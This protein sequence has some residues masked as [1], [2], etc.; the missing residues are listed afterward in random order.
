[1][2]SG[3]YINQK[4]KY[5]MARKNTAAQEAPDTSNVV[6]EPG[7]TNPIARD[8]Y[9]LLDLYEQYK[10]KSAVIRFLGSKGYKTGDIAR[11]MD[12]IYQHARNV[13]KQQPKKK[14]APEAP[15]E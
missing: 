6:A 10:T 5:N 3:T 15:V 12:I 14:A 4:E 2:H 8:G 7:G 1:M 11:F 13:L 9:N